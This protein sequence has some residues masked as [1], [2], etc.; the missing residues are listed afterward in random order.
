M[1]QLVLRP[2]APRRRFSGRSCGRSF[3]Q[4]QSSRT[5]VPPLNARSLGPWSGETLHRDRLPLSEPG[6]IL[7]LQRYGAAPRHAD[8]DLLRG[9]A[10]RRLGGRNEALHLHPK[11]MMRTLLIAV[12]ALTITACSS[13]AD[14]DREGAVTQSLE[15]IRANTHDAPMSS[16]VE[17]LL[18]SAAADFHA[19]PPAKALHF[20]TVRIGSLIT[21]DGARRYMLC[22]DFLSENG[23]GP[24]APF[25]TIESPGGPN[26]YQQLIGKNEL[27]D[28]PSASFGIASDLSPSLQSR[29]D[30]L[31]ANAT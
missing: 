17:F 3:E 31:Q 24:G 2:G 19:H 21:S 30:S 29:F 14:R 1:D 23:T 12:A 20:H 25:M 4:R 27:C 7:L 9:G 26:G 16:T 6:D 22:G 10:H 13:D 5:A 8:V 28:D 11:Q 18:Q 15:V